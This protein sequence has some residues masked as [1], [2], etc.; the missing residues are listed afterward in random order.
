MLLFRKTKQLV[1]GMALL[2]PVFMSLIAGC[3][4]DKPAPKSPAPIVAAPA[5]PVDTA[6]AALAQPTAAPNLATTAPTN[7]LVVDSSAGGKG[8]DDCTF[9]NQWFK[10]DCDAEGTR[11]A[12]SGDEKFIQEEMADAEWCSGVGYLRVKAL[13]RQPFMENGVQK[14]VLLTGMMPE[15]KWGDAKFSETLLGASIWTKQKN[16]WKLQTET[17]MITFLQSNIRKPMQIQFIEAGQLIEI[18][19]KEGKTDQILRIGVKNGQFEPLD[20]SNH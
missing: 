6:L 19:Y 15:V 9:L 14:M 1:F 17:K 18:R 20:V 7:A 4:R 11:F 8:L 16:S 13:F 10:N 3:K 5:A 12:C 2:T